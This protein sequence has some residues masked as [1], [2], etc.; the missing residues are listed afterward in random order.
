MFKRVFTICA[1]IDE[2]ILLYPSDVHRT[3]GPFTTKTEAVAEG[4]VDLD[5][6][7]YRK[8]KPE[9]EG[10]LFHQV[11]P[12]AGLLPLL[13]EFDPASTE[14]EPESDVD[15]ELAEQLAGWKMATDPQI[16]TITVN[17]KVSQELLQQANRSLDAVE[18]P[19]LL[20][21]RGVEDVDWRRDAP[22][23]RHS[24][25]SRA[26]FPTSKAKA[27][28]C[29]V[30]AAVGPPKKHYSLIPPGGEEWGRNLEAQLQ[31][32]DW[33]PLSEEELS[34]WLSYYPVEQQHV[35][36]SGRHASAT[37][38]LGADAGEELSQYT[39]ALDHSLVSILPE[40]KHTQVHGLHQQEY[41]LV[42]IIGTH[43]SMLQLLS[44]VSDCQTSPPDI[45]FPRRCSGYI[46][47]VP[48]SSWW[49]S[50]L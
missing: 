14:E 30:S 27:K 44:F 46:R 33:E 43:F 32:T 23:Y 6:E 11:Y 22:R 8:P 49:E 35:P 19:P 18:A 42:T 45:Q 24:D 25:P 48:A 47:A 50:T 26:S 3:V 28:L 9:R 4:H 40:R 15:G 12:Y 37:S 41:F 17:V 38:P 1:A 36:S 10:R 29:G 13:G 20:D 21:Y 31:S 16:S 7:L 2:K 34:Q 5:Q 39:S